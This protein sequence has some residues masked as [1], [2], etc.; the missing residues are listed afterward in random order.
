MRVCFLAPLWNKGVH[1]RGWIEELAH[2]GVQCFTV[3]DSDGNGLPC[4]NY[5]ANPDDGLEHEKIRYALNNPTDFIRGKLLGSDF[6]WRFHGHRIRKRLSDW[7]VSILHAHYLD[8]FAIL[9]RYVRFRPWVASAWGSDLAKVESDSTTAG[10][11]SW[12]LLDAD[13]VHVETQRQ[14]RILESIGLPRERLLVQN[15]GVRADIFRPGRASLKLREK[16]GIRRNDIVLLS[17]RAHE[18]NYSVDLILRALALLRKYRPIVRC[19][20][21]SSGAE[22]PNL[23]KLAR[24]L[25]IEDRVRFVGDL[26]HSSLPAYCRIADAYVQAPVTDGVSY[27]LL[28]AMSSGLPVITTGTGD[29]PEN[30]RDGGNGFFFPV[31]RADALAERITSLTKDRKMRSRMGKRAR[32]WV[33]KNCDRRASFD[34]FVSRYKQLAKA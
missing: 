2:R 3:S 4:F 14:A 20:I 11:V 6:A 9:A 1:V 22:T 27:A 28:E 12:A 18:Q 13:L 34:L 31:G 21:A 30:V 7:G 16:L 15:W 10:K 8:P 25:G 32:E 26:P 5:L 24:Q 17:L 29:T 33:L 19:V 23:Q